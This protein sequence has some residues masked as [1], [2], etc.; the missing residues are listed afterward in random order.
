MKIITKNNAEWKRIVGG[1]PPI[2]MDFGRAF[3]QE[4]EEDLQKDDYMTVEL[5]LQWMVMGV[6][7]NHILIEV[8]WNKEHTHALGLGV[9]CLGNTGAHDLYL[10][11]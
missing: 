11:P 4:E 9:E 2:P 10:S 7:H 3:T 5:K 6:S 8:S 1:T